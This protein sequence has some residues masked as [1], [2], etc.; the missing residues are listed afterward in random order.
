MRL[1]PILALIT[2]LPIPI[3]SVIAAPP[4][5]M[6]E[7][8]SHLVEQYINKYQQYA[9]AE[10][11]RMGIPASIKLAQAIQESRYGQSLLAIE[12]NNHFGIK[13]HTSWTGEEYFVTTGEYVNGIY[14]SQSD[15]CFRKYA[16]V[17][18]SYEDHSN[19]LASRQHYNALFKIS[20]ADYV[21]WA[22]GL[23]KA[24]Y[25]TDPE[26]DKKLVQVIKQYNLHRFDQAVTSVFLAPVSPVTQSNSGALNQQQQA[27]LDQVES[28]LKTLE[29]V[30]KATQ[31]HYSFLGE[32]QKELNTNLESLQSRQVEIIDETNNRIIAL[33]QA[34]AHQS[35]MIQDLQ[36]R[37]RQ[38]ES[39]QQS[40][41]LSDPLKSHF[42][43]DG[44]PKTQVEI[45]PQRDLNNDLVFYQ[46]NRKATYLHED[47]TLMTVA[48]AYGVSYT[49]LLKFNDLEEDLAQYPENFYIYLERKANTL[50]GE[51]QAYHQ[52]NQGENMYLLSQ[53]YGIRYQRLLQMNY[54]KKGEE[55]AVGEF[56]A[57]ME[58]ANQ[59]PKLTSEVTPLE[60]KSTDFGAGGASNDK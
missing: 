15:A 6:A 60:S 31:H 12:A 48:S 47:Q 33:D 34:L 25:A 14:Q 44:T 55:P 54:M 39:V 41:L 36:R 3:G 32:Q 38:L 1:R 22:E 21:A 40:M 17:K 59:K 43:P 35:A 30:L 5:M 37:V 19:F 8:D 20:S 42:N 4:L 24:G 56:V 51:T 27:R 18:E 46:S 7:E 58:N 50:E 28:Q 9:V 16:T 53:R 45:F 57:L 2:S 11:E 52:V 26:Y 23:K 49:D 10:M 13:C 29:T